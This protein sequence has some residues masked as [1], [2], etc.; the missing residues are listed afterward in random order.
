MSLIL[1]IDAGNSRMK[2]GLH[3]ARGWVTLGATP[4]G[5]IGTLALR[6]WQNLPRP[7]RVVGV[8]VAGEAARLRI[9]ALLARWRL[10]PQW[11]TASAAACGVVNG[12]ATP[13][14]LGADRWAALVAARRRVGATDLFPAPV[15]VVNAG[16]AVTIDALDAGGRFRGGVI[17]P[18]LRLML[19]ALADNT[20]ALKS[21]PGQYQDFPTRTADALYSGAVQAICGAIELAR[22]RMR[23]DDAAVKCLLAGGAAAE[24]AP[25][26]SGHPEIVDNLVLEGVLALAQA[27]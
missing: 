18:G 25:H 9:E 22:T 24:I 10:V 1:V 26:L 16:T 11:L 14:Q 15:V 20:S 8:N 19:Q 27:G 23:H 12:Y 6:E 4:N 3:S 13:E 2:W 5:E 21:A 17:V 7:A